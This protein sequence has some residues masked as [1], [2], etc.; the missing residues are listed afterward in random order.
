MPLA[1]KAWGAMETTI[2]RYAGL[3]KLANC[4]SFY[5]PLTLPKSFRQRQTGAHD[6]SACSAVKVSGKS[7]STLAV[8]GSQR[9]YKLACNTTAAAIGR[10]VFNAVRIHYH[11]DLNDGYPS[12]GRSNINSD[13]R[14]PQRLVSAWCYSGS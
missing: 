12:A 7:P 14:H 10:H 2:V 8:S 6:D 1:G 13:W 3:Q 9:K 11:K 5:T 4:Q